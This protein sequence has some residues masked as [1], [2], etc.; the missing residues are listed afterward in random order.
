MEK[1]RSRKGNYLYNITQKVHDEA[2]TRTHVTDLLS[3]SL[4]P[5]E[6]NAAVTLGRAVTSCKCIFWGHHF[7]GLSPPP[8]NLYLVLKTK[9]CLTQI[10]IK[11]GEARQWG[12]GKGRESLKKWPCGNCRKIFDL[13][14]LGEKE[15]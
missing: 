1:W 11:R 9:V 8:Y 2:G 7:T 12:P 6:N 4:S 15:L 10:E 14:V 5:K 13:E 3:N